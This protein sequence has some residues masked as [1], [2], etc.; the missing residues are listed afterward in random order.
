[1]ANLGGYPRNVPF[2]HAA[3][4]ALVEKLFATRTE[5]NRQLPDREQVGSRARQSWEGPYC[6]QFDGLIQVCLRDAQRFANTLGA[7]VGQLEYLA[8]RAQ[9]EQRRREAARAG[10]VRWRAACAQYAAAGQPPPPVD[11]YVPQTPPIQPP[12]IPPIDCPPTPRVPTATA[13]GGT[14]QSSRPRGSRDR[15]RC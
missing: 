8:E 12:T 13:A 1:M 5:L 15:R 3:A 9:W 6:Q 10:L 14:G 4:R 7:A 2:N 11:W